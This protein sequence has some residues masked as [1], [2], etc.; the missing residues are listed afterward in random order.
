MADSKGNGFPWAGVAVLAAFVGSTQLVPHAFD[1][2]R[3]PEKLRA[4]QAVNAELEVD[5]RLW[6]DPFTALRRFEA[7]RAE[8][9]E[10]TKKTE[11]IKSCSGGPQKLREP[12]QLRRLLD[13]NGDSDL[14]ESLVVLAMVP[15]NPFVGA[16]ET[17]RRLRYAILAGLQAKGYVP[18][19]AERIGLLEFDTQ[20]L[21]RDCRPVEELRADLSA[22]P[23]A[24]A[25]VLEATKP[26][27]DCP[28]VQFKAGEI[29]G[30]E[31][32]TVPYEML[33]KQDKFR[34][35]DVSGNAQRFEQV[36]LLWIDEAALPE[37]KLDSLARMLDA[38]FGP[39]VVSEQAPCIKK[40]KTVPRLA[41]I[42]PSS[43][44]A[45]RMVVNELRVASKA[46]ADKADGVVRA[47]VDPPQTCGCLSPDLDSSSGKARCQMARIPQ[48]ARQG[49]R[50]LA[51]AEILNAG[52][53]ASDNMLDDLKRQKI[54][55][56]LNEQFNRML[57]D[58]P[59]VTIDFK[60]TI[61]T[62]DVLIKRLVGELQ[63]RL[64]EGAHRR[65]VVIAERDSTYSQL[66]LSEL[67][68]R[69]RDFH[70]LT[71]DP[72][73]FFRG[74]DGV[75]TL[76]SSR[77]EPDK[78]SANRNGKAETALEWPESRDQLDYLRRQ[79]QSLKSSE[80]QA[81]ADP[82]GAIGIFGN[83]VHDK[84]LVLQALHDTFADKVFFTTDMD[85]RFL[86]P[87]T[88]AFTRNLIVASSLPLEFYRP[89]AGDLDLQAG[90]PPFRNVYQTAAFLAARQAGCRSVECKALE[91]KAEL[92]ALDNPSLYEVG[93]SGVVPLSG[94]ALTQRPAQSAGS[95]ALV[96]G[97][98]VLLMLGGLLVWPS[99]PAI[100]EVR[101]GFLNYPPPVISMTLPG[102]VLVALYSAL[103]A[104]VL[105]SLIEFVHPQQ[106]SFVQTLLLAALSG[107]GA[108]LA[109]LTTLL[110][111]RASSSKTAAGVDGLHAGLLLLVAVAWVW[112][113][114]PAASRPACQDCEPVTWLDGVSAWPSHLIH[115]FALMVI[116]CA[117]DFAW[118]KTIG[119]R[120][121]DT[122][123]LFLP[124][125]RPHS[126]SRSNFR[127]LWREWLDHISIAN[128]KCRPGTS[129]RFLR[130]WLQYGSR[131]ESGPRALRSAVMYGLTVLLIG[132][133]F[134]A[135]NDGQVP[136]VPVRGTEHRQLV[137]ATLYAI[138]LL[139]PLLVAAV[140]D[141]TLLLF[142]F[143]RHLNAG[144][145]VYPKRVIRHFAAALGDRDFKAWQFRFQALPADRLARTKRASACHC[146]LDDWLDV[147][148]V[149][150]R[151]EL[152]SG[153]VIG[154]F[155]VLALLVV[156]RSS[157]FDNWSL[158]PAIAISACVYLGWLILLAAL[159]KL[160]A[161]N[162]RRRALTSMNADLQ[163]LCGQKDAELAQ[164]VE[165]FKRLIASVEGNQTGAFAGL[166]DQPL[167]KALLVPL[168]G[169]G[170]TQLFER[171][172]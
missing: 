142:S 40:E 70:N 134:F 94:Y 122:D 51:G 150:R 68:F 101:S 109:V 100:R 118:F 86:H 98:I 26:A 63:L 54:E 87:R 62:D 140:A 19:N 111:R 53:T 143:I 152:V 97:L 90:T 145:T 22:S 148:V 52:S 85:A 112:M 121:E 139:L 162:T 6:E 141:A 14:S 99:T 80:S 77:D 16:E 50:L 27:M 17:R 93:R 89:R 165:P 137:Q 49:Y 127:N 10:K 159:L 102:V 116:L 83:D 56:F 33:S 34:E 160:A 114:W 79:A 108:L 66:L 67:K 151:T 157:L 74:I 1:Q 120:K 106:V 57:G 96:A 84:L 73:Y 156:A 76:N 149:A 72:Y 31:K 91:R 155:F 129:H 25:P 30:L 167:L 42:G 64:P 59:P 35:V 69:L 39:Q 166:F 28:K 103:G 5:A 163:W 81:G 146:L 154:P 82:I 128:W 136:M 71:L 8:R 130:L 95:R 9:C 36:A 18:D 92:K 2:L 38:M 161:E 170:G 125:L 20:G 12:R 29:A 110:L 124:T 46:F 4:Q 43:T 55:A 24:G 147:Q 75:T 171:L 13:R 117:M 119:R 113:A 123:W 37:S 107:F 164:L 7:E 44:D 88:Q 41:V 21:K 172:L 168:G 144:R 48:S 3:P 138:L 153:L 78:G 126:M 11:E 58:K 47:Q 23:A 105:C 104:Y 132:S 65:V 45:L 169:A 135:L 115:L 60:R 15:G 131:G 158:T 61:S 32:F 133:L